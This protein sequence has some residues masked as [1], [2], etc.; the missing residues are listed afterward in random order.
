LPGFAKRPGRPP[1]LPTS[2]LARRRLAIQRVAGPPHEDVAAVVAALGAVQAQDFLGALWAL[3]LRSG[4]RAEAEVERAIAERRIVRTWPMRYTLHLVP[5]A[6]AR[7]MLELLAPRAVARAA[8][9]YRGL[10]LDEAA[11]GLARKGLERALRGGRRL[12]RDAAYRVLADVGVPPDGQRGIH[13]LSRLAQEAFLVFGPREG[14][15]HTFAL[16]DEWLRPARRLARDEALATIAARYFEGHGPATLQ[17]FTWWTGLPVAAAREAITLAGARVARE[18]EAGVARFV[19][20]ARA[21]RLPAA[22]G[23]RL[24]PAF[25]ELLVGY[26]DRSAFVAPEHASRLHALLSP[27]I[28][29]EGRVAGTW[30][31]TLGGDA[32]IVR[33]AWFEAPGAAAARALRA[34]AEAY[35]AFLGRRL[36]LDVGAPGG[37]GASRGRAAR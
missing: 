25:D 24:L 22:I 6:D 7:W 37:A 13:V 11:F 18:D 19:G 21:P 31:R 34:A 3:G 8:S 30:T 36:V 33:P 35:A 15:Q 5:A 27:A 2:A 4:A 10:G 29:L 9:R 20:A 14:R 23:A 32:V 1:P 28:L 17:D 12:T 26:R 16:F